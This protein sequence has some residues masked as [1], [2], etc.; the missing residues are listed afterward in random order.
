MALLILASMVAAAA[1]GIL[2][3]LQAALLAAGAMVLTRCV[4]EDAARKSVDWPLLVAIGASFGLGAAL[5]KTGAA[6]SLAG[7]LLAYA[8]DNPWTA[9]AVIYATTTIVSELVTNNAAPGVDQATDTG[10]RYH[11]VSEI[12]PIPIPSPNAQSQELISSV[13][14]PAAFAA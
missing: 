1:T 5:Q 7:T 11:K 14:A 10:W 12:V 8:G 9:L 13:E 3:M 2:S 4:S 6:Q